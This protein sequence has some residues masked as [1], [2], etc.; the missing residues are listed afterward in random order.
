MQPTTFDFGNGIIVYNSYEID[1]HT[2]FD[3]QEIELNEDL[4][5]VKFP[6]QQILL[7]VGWWPAGNPQGHFV[8]TVAQDQDWESQF[9]QLEACDVSSLRAAIANAVKFINNRKV[10]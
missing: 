9:L 2:P 10:L 1:E 5:L 4:I 8:V 6:E 7:D 3:R